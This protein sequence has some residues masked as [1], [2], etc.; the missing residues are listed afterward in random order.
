M[1]RATSR[2]TRS[3]VAAAAL[4]ALAGPAEAADAPGFVSLFDGRSLA[5]WHASAASSHSAASGN[6][7][8]GRWAVEGGAIAGTQD[9]PG[10]GGILVSDEIAGCANRSFTYFKSMH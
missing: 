2:R 9:I 7:S 3:A 10:N 8:G 6:R 1:P 5:G 4:L